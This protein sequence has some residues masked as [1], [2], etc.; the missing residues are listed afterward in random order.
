MVFFLLEYSSM[1][2]VFKRQ[3]TVVGEDECKQV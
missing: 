2:M 3:Y 1:A